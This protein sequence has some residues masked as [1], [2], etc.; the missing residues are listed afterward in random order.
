MCSSDPDCDRH[1]FQ[2]VSPTHAH[3]FRQEKDGFSHSAPSTH[4]PS[5]PSVHTPT[6]DSS[7]SDDLD[8]NLMILDSKTP[9]LQFSGLFKRQNTPSKKNSVWPKSPGS[10][11]PQVVQGAWHSPP[12]EVQLPK[13]HKK[14]KKGGNK[15]KIWKSIRSFLKPEAQQSIRSLLKP[16]AQPAEQ[17][18]AQPRA[19]QDT[20]ETLQREHER[21]HKI[22][23]RS[24][25]LV[26]GVPPST[27]ATE[28]A[29]QERRRKALQAVAVRR[30]YLRAA[31][32]AAGRVRK[33][34]VIVKCRNLKT[35]GKN[36]R[37]WLAAFEKIK[38]HKRKKSKKGEKTDT[39]MIDVKAIW[40][41]LSHTE[42]ATCVD[43]I[44]FTQTLK[45]Q[46]RERQKKPIKLRF[47]L[48][49][50]TLNKEA[51]AKRDKEVEVC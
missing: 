4:T 14:E 28:K 13:K 30:K 23:P 10:A 41:C 51:S 3:A 43:S 45:V 29:E 20:T 26:P 39:S 35:L 18:L 33:R 37:V 11:Q 8:N 49:D 6:Q 22:T 46:Q 47:C 50:A 32:R 24:L 16:E 19:T 38:S 7:S 27:W 15:S 31:K 42:A 5:F 12:P 9:T 40:R 1:P 48:Y 36:H 44:N 2:L 25:S 34:D 21:E 17:V